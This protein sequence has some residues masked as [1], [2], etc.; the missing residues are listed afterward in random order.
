MFFVP[1]SDQIVLIL[2]I[3][4]LELRSRSRDDSIHFVSV[5]ENQNI[6]VSGDQL[7]FLV[8][9]SNSFKTC[10][11]NFRFLHHILHQDDLEALC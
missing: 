6:P 7:V 9:S 1:N 3:S 8:K 10:L 11:Q 5:L 2:V 4:Y